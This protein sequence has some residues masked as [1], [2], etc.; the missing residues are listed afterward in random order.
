[1]FSSLVGGSLL[2]GACPCAGVPRTRTPGLRMMPSHNI[3]GF[4][5]TSP[6]HCVPLLCTLTLFVNASSHL[7]SLLFFQAARPGR[8]VGPAPPVLPSLAEHGPPSALSSSS[9]PPPTPPLTPSPPPPPHF[10]LDLVPLRQAARPGRG[11][12]RGAREVLRARVGPP[13]AAARVQ[14]VEGQ[15]VQVG[16]RAWERERSRELRQ[17]GYVA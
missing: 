4:R 8:R 15:R 12:G 6:I 17:Q 5:P 3:S 11:V 14:P 10:W 1:M 13:H 2:V 7:R 9:S 16:S